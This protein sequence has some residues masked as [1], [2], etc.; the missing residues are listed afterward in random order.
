[1]QPLLITPKNV[2]IDGFH[3]WRLSQDDRKLVEKYGCMVPCAVLDVTDAEARILTVRMN[4]AKGVHVAV[5]MADLVQELIDDSGMTMKEVAKAIGATTD[6]VKILYED[7][8]FKSRNLANAPYSKAWIPRESRIHGPKPADLPSPE[9]IV[10]N[11]G[12]AQ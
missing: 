4:R 3:R 5:R 12:V 1:V 2:I 9:D 10:D 8:I 11:P 7:S 6:E